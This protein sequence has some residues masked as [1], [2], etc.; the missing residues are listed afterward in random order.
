MSSRNAAPRTDS[1]SSRWPSKDAPGGLRE[2]PSRRSRPIAELRVVE[3]GLEAAECGKRV[4]R[5]QPVLLLR[6]DSGAEHGRSRGGRRLTHIDAR[7][8]SVA[9]RGL[10][11]PSCQTMSSSTSS[12]PDLTDAV[13]RR[14][15]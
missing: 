3:R 7:V 10:G 1:S 14:L 9:E 11:A 15:G 13:K 2:P 6:A 4:D 8:E 12:Q 5:Q